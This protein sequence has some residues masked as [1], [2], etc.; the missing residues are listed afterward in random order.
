MQSRVVMLFWSMDKARTFGSSLT[1]SVQFKGL[2]LF[3]SL[4]AQPLDVCP[5]GDLALQQW[6]STFRSSEP[7]SG[8]CVFETTIDPTS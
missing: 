3:E 7:P 2:I 8:L 4:M 1:V 5:I 6:V